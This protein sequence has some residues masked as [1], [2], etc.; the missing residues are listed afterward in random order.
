M[1]VRFLA[2]S[3]ARCLH[4]FPMA[5]L[6]LLLLPCRRYAGQPADEPSSSAAAANGSA[7][8]GGAGSSK[9]PA[10]GS[11]RSSAKGGKRARGGTQAAAAEEEDDDI[12]PVTGG[13][14]SEQGYWKCK[15]CTVNNFD[16]GATSC[17]VC[18]LP[19]PE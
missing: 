13:S 2:G 14:I 5:V 15:V 9:A 11:S 10:G 4:W 6:T 18:G 16:L 19:R 7:S 17:E 1:D 3:F 8:T 12:D